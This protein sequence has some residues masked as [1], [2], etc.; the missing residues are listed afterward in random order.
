LAWQI[1]G[2]TL[3]SAEPILDEDALLGRMRYI[4]SHGV[5]EGLVETPE[6]WPGLTSIPEIVHGLKRLFPWYDWS[7][8]V[9]A[10]QRKKYLTRNHFVDFHKIVLSRLPAFEEFNE[11]DYRALMRNILNQA[12]THARAKHE[13][14]N[15][16]GK[17]AGGFW[18]VSVVWIDTGAVCVA[19]PTSWTL[20]VEVTVGRRNA[21]GKCF[22]QW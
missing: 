2:K 10:R 16:L 13:H 7:K 9:R 1:Q 17:Q 3:F 21:I 11:K 18:L 15:V 12:N 8:F 19:D 6:Q 5:K 20:L 22:P 14:K 4:F